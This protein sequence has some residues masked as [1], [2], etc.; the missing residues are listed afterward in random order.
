MAPRPRGRVVILRIPRAMNSPAAAAALSTY[1]RRAAV[2]PRPS[3]EDVMLAVG[4]QRAALALVISIVKTSA[5]AAA[6]S[7]ESKLALWRNLQ[8][9][10]YGLSPGSV[11]L[12]F[13]LFAGHALTRRAAVLDKPGRTGLQPQVE[14]GKVEPVQDRVHLQGGRPRGETGP[15]DANLGHGVGRQGQRADPPL[16]IGARRLDNDLIDEHLHQCASQRLAL[17]IA[18]GAPDG[19]GAAA[20]EQR[21]GQQCPAP[22]ASDRMRGFMVHG[23]PP[24]CRPL[25]PGVRDNF[26]QSRRCHHR[27]PWMNL[28]WRKQGTPY[29]QGCRRWLAFGD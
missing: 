20:D 5:Q 15:A 2:T 13:A 3:L 25:Q 26:G 28:I 4:T 9:V 19:P 1:A 16:R 29:W 24:S 6:S 8:N 21:Q 17:G 22:G 23:G 11:L 10:W 7:I 12:A 14:A 27:T 18:H